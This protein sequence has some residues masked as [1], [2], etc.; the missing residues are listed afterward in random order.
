M[1]SFTYPKTTG[2]IG[3][4]KNLSTVTL[5]CILRL[6]VKTTVRHISICIFHYIHAKKQW[7]RKAFFMRQGW[8]SQS[9]LKQLHQSWILKLCIPSPME[10]NRCIFLKKKL[11]RDLEKS[12][13]I[14]NCL[15]KPFN[16]NMLQSKTKSSQRNGIWVPNEGFTFLW[17][18]ESLTTSH[19]RVLC[20]AS[21][22]KSLR[23]KKSQ[24]H[25]QLNESATCIP[26]FK[27]CMYS[28]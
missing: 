15:Y 16:L 27:K 3:I 9:C 20:E 18:T 4:W 2:I 17:L 1:L 13:M 10:S 22:C 25:I 21:E 14:S 5:S 24:P 12:T 7:A 23:N 26:K 8:E 11:V 19:Q 28:E 6:T